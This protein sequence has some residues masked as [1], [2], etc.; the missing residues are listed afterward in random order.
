MQGRA[1]ISEVGGVFC[2]ILPA[3]LFALRLR[4][5]KFLWSDAGLEKRCPRCKEYWPYDTEFYYSSSCKSDGLMDWCRACYMEWRYPIRMGLSD[6]HE[7]KKPE[8]VAEVPWEQRKAN[9]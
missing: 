7:A 9:A 4:S 1:A 3:R 8:P 2:P 5:G 6:Q